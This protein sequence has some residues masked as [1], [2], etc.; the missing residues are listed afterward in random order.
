VGCESH[1]CRAGTRTLLN[2]AST[3]GT[4]LLE[5]SEKVSSTFT[6]PRSSSWQYV[7]MLC[8]RR[9]PDT[10]RRT[11]ASRVSRDVQSAPTCALYEPRASSA[12]VCRKRRARRRL[13]AGLVET[14]WRGFTLAESVGC[15]LRGIGDHSPPNTDR[16]AAMLCGTMLE[17]TKAREAADR[18]QEVK[19]PVACVDKH[20]KA[21][22]TADHTLKRSRA[23]LQK[24]KAL[25]VEHKSMW[26]RCAKACLRG[27]P[28]VLK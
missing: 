19:T 14:E 28:E 20:T 26:R 24:S 22:G 7:W 16:A 13:R 11:Q 18:K 9:G 3:E 12:S 2:C 4:P 6:E 27:R 25:V 1:P 23:H 8:Q 17:H 5:E 10:P 21:V 15:V